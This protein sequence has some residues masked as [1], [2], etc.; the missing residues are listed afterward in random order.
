MAEQTKSMKESLLI[1]IAAICMGVIFL[2]NKEETSTDG[3]ALTKGLAIENDS[4][5]H[6]GVTVTAN[7]EWA[8]DTTVHF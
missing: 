7:D 1:I 4:T 3:C 5:K 2:C 8:G 6:G